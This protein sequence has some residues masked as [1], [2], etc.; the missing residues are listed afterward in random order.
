MQTIPFARIVSLRQSEL[1]A[2][3]DGT[4]R[5]VMYMI[6]TLINGGVMIRGFHREEN[7]LETLFMKITGG[8]ADRAAI[9]PN[10]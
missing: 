9:K 6:S 3:V 10:N 2:S 1:V 8:G 7:N 5:E 4:D